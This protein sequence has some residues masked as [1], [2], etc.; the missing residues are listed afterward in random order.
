VTRRLLAALAALLLA[1][2]GAVVLLAY[3]RAADARALA[4]VQ[5]VDVLVVDA[6]VPSGTPGEELPDLVR[7]ERLPVKAAV[8]GRVTDLGQLAGRVA[9]A[10]LQPGEQ[11]LAAR[12]AAPEDLAVP[13]TVSPPAGASEISVVLEPQRAVGGRLT[14]GDEIGVYVSMTLENE[15]GK[16]VGATHAALH[17]VLVTQVQGAPAP[18]GDG[19]TDTASTGGAAPTGS[20]L[21]TMALPARDAEKVVFAMEHGSVWLS[22][23]P[24]GADSSDTTI[25]TQGNVY[26]D[27]SGLGTVYGESG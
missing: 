13:G 1:A 8:E 20:L 12:F 15:A 2:T 5:T 17:G 18:A 25:V 27:V 4:G 10:D 3:V 24:E 11:L 21:V 22:L 26:G 16:T 19:S 6:P 9:T 14:A 7:T 23:E